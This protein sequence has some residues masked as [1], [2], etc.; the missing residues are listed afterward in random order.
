MDYETDLRDEYLK[1]DYGRV[2]Y[3]QHEGEG[4]VIVFLHGLAASTRTWT[5]L[6]R[7]LPDNLNIYLIDLLGHG[8]SDK[9]EI[10][11]TVKIQV[12]ILNLFVES[13]GLKDYYVFG[14]SYGGWIATSYALNGYKLKGL[15]LEDSGGLKEFFD[16]VRGTEPRE[17][18]KN[19]MLKKALTLN[20]D[21][22]VM[23]SILDDEFSEHLFTPEDL[24]RIDIPTLIIWGNEDEI[25]N[26]KFSKVFNENIRGSRLELISDA[27]H[28][29][30][31]THYR[32]VSDVLLRFMSEDK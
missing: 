26:T 16:E 6:V 25:I 28:T 24:Q 5:R 17:Q 8:E 18:Y 19:E 12:D 2:H 11:Y 1:T 7:H 30:H 31:Y 32:K 3:I 29:P 14:H 13:K 20:A 23:Q 9:P 21:R 27:K 4:K 15:I 22:Y 10:D